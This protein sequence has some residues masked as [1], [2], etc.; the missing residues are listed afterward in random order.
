MA[1]ILDEYLTKEQAAAELGKR[2]RTLDRWHVERRGPKRTKIGRSIYFS[3]KKLQSFI[4]QQT[5]DVADACA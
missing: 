3:R 2:P 1:L 5:E 4:E